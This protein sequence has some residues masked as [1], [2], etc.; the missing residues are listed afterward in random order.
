MLF[1]TDFHGLDTDGHGFLVRLAARVL[2]QIARIYTNF[3]VRLAAR[4]CHR[5]REFT[6]I[7]FETFGFK[8]IY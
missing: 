2:P 6:Q 4:F 3:L 5:W 7:D 1:D 8:V